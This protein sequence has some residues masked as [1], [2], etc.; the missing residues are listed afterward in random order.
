MTAC[1]FDPTRASTVATLTFLDCRCVDSVCVWADRPEK[2]ELV[3]RQDL[4]TP[5]STLESFGS[6][7]GLR[8]ATEASDDESWGEWKGGPACDERILAGKEDAKPKTRP[9]K[10]ETLSLTRSSVDEAAARLVNA[11]RWVADAKK[12]LQ[13]AEAQGRIANL[14]MKLKT[15]QNA[16]GAE[17]KIRPSKKE[18][19]TPARVPNTRTAARLGAALAHLKKLL[20]LTINVP[21]RERP[22]LLEIAQNRIIYLE[23]TLRKARGAMRRGSKGPSGGSQ[24]NKRRGDRTCE[25]KRS[26]VP[27]PKELIGLEAATEDGEPICFAY[28]LPGGCNKAAK[29][30]EKCSK[31]LH[32][33]VKKGCKKHHPYVGSH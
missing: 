7:T 18:T 22:A 17:L 8:T 24:N 19:L 15:L 25:G 29:W 16:E 2:Q 6:D 26:R 20:R 21:R 13:D 12:K 1:P 23:R 30:G 28:N 27:M 3:A 4:L 5:H 14:K 9:S 11:E 32:V 31:G 10:G 33:C